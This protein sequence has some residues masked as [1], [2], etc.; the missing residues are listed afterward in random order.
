M[1]GRRGLRLL[2]SISVYD[3]GVRRF[4]LTTGSYDKIT[5]LIIISK[6]GPTTGLR[7]NPEPCSGSRDQPR[8]RGWRLRNSGHVTHGGFGS[9]RPPLELGGD[10]S[11]GPGGLPSRSSWWGF[12]TANAILY[13]TIPSSHR[14]G[15][16]ML[17]A[18]PLRCYIYCKNVDFCI[19]YFYYS[20]V[21]RRPE[22]NM[23]GQFNACWP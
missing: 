4:T 8:G 2:I 20:P 1:C 22:T 10:S 7:R 6:S 14:G 19:V 16:H 11:K 12:F 13:P 9:C 3:S 23:D 17:A 5:G 21:V 15:D 18:K